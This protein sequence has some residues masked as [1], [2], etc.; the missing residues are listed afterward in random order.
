[1]KQIAHLSLVY[2]AHEALANLLYKYP[3]AMVALF[4]AS[5]EASYIN[6]DIVPVDDG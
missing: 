1:M 4:L 6:G 3:E 2:I 5:D